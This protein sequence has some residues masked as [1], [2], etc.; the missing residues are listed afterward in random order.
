MA[1]RLVILALAALA[2]PQAALAE[3]PT[4]EAQAELDACV[5]KAG[6]VDLDVK[7]CYNEFA[8]RE[9]ERLN[10]AWRELIR[11][12]GGAKSDEGAALLAEQRAWLGFRD[13]SCFHWIAAPYPGTLD[14]LS[15]A[16]CYAEVVTRRA[17]DIEILR[18]TYQGISGESAD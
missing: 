7:D 18:D 14:R 4:A 3:G 10:K 15:F 9:D 11:I 17:D 13:Q 1:T 12:V 16:I 5:E 6:M 8:G 2:L